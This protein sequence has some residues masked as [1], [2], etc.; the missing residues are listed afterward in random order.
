MLMNDESLVHEELWLRSNK[1]VYGISVRG[2]LI[3]AII[4]TTNLLSGYTIPLD[5]YSEVV[6]C[7]ELGHMM[8]C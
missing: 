5:R 2:E 4:L 6:P 1:K 8:M 3:Q 7:L